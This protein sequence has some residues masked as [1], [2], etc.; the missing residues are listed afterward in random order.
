MKLT[1]VVECQKRLVTSLVQ[2][3]MYKEKKLSYGVRRINETLERVIIMIITMRKK[4][5]SQSFCDGN[6]RAEAFITQSCPSMRHCAYN[7]RALC[8][9]LS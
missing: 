7:A 9:I 8:F 1:G 2:R 3:Y 4:N 5:T 6:K